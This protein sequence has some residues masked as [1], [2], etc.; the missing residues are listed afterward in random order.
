MGIGD[1]LTMLVAFVLG[2]LAA[3]FMFLRGLIAPPRKSESR[4][5]VEKLKAS[6]DAAKAERA[7]VEAAKVEEVREA[8]EA[9]KKLD[10]V[11]LAND[12]IRRS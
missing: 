10:P 7:A 6:I 8:V 2:V 3:A 1:I 4:E 11:A 12:I 5:A 9:E